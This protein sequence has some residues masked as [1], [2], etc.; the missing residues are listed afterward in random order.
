MDCNT[1]IIIFPLSYQIY[2]KGTQ[3]ASAYSKPITIGVHTFR[4]SKAIIMKQTEL[5]FDFNSYLRKHL[6]SFN[7]MFRGLEMIIAIELYVYWFHI[8]IIFQ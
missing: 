7:L 8:Y 2:T 6:F 3:H 1:P 4:I 5:Y